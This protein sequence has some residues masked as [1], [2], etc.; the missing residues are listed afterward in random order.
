MIQ[1]CVAMIHWCTNHPKEHNDPTSF[2]S[3]LGEFVVECLVFRKLSI[4]LFLTSRSLDVGN[5]IQNEIVAYVDFSS[6]NGLRSSKKRQHML[7]HL[8]KMVFLLH[9]GSIC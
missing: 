7:V 8:R 4:T 3:L 9:I 2:L 6:S 5:S 1:V